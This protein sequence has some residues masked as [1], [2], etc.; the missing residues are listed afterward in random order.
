M[1]LDIRKLI[2]SQIAQAKAKSSHKAFTLFINNVEKRIKIEK[3][4]ECTWA[5]LWLGV[6]DRGSTRGE[7]GGYSKGQH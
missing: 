5:M 2:Q 3:S 6:Q 1:Y 7:L 4:T